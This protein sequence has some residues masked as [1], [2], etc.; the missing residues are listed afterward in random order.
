M[1]LIA[2]VGGT[3]VAGRAVV[4][5]ALDSGHRVRSL[6]RHLPA[7]DNRVQRAEYVQAEVHTGA[8]MDGGLDG[9][10]VLIETMDARAGAA[11]RSLPVATVSVLAAAERAGVGRCVLLTI[12]NA[13]ECPMG[14]YQVQAARALSYERSAMA[15]SVVYATQFHNL[16]AGIFS[17]GAKAGIIPAF[18]GVS[19]Q[20]ISTADVAAV[21][22]AQA[23]GD[24]SDKASVQAGGPAVHAMDEL[25]HMWKTA[26]GSRAR[27]THLPLPGAFGA[28]LRAG[29]NLVPDHAVGVESFESWLAN[30]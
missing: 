12:V 15:T 10:D 16:V 6:S 8:G 9:V 24:S 18:R 28:F 30:R 23:L 11:L 2:V 1:V 22:V 21:L 13:G 26:T 29:R 27:V 14:Y 3:G 4:A 25:G 17:G 7:A 19:F 5:H 20:P